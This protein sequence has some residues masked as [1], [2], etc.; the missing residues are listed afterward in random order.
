[1]DLV[2]DGEGEDLSDAGDRGEEG[3]GVGVVAE[4]SDGQE[5]SIRV[6]RQAALLAAPGL[7]SLAGVG[8]YSLE[9]WSQPSTRSVRAASA[10]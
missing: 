9:W 5:E 1:M 2:E 3:E 6:A 10:R 4:G 8:A 7:T